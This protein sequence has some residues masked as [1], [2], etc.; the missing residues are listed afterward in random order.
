MPVR[1]LYQTIK[2][3]SPGQKVMGLDIGGK[4][5]GLAIG[6]QGH[7]IASPYRILWRRK[8][9]PDA[10]SLID[11]INE[12][13][14]GALILGWPLNMDGSIGPSCD[15]VRDFAHAFIRLHDLP[16]SFQDER[17]STKAVDQEMIAADMTRKNRAKR[18]DALAATWIL[19]SAFDRLQSEM[20]KHSQDL[21]S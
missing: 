16:I 14:I 20:D 7:K 4:T 21:A 17:L 15:S 18:R 13:N 12:H 8:F 11:D 19:Q 5:I 2:L 9:T 3:I 10:H 1:N 6:D